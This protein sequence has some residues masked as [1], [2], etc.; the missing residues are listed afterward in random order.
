MEDAGL[1]TAPPYAAPSQAWYTVGVLT[2]AWLFAYLDRQI[3]I[4]LIESLRSSIALS[5][6]QISLVQGF[7]FSLFFVLAGIPIGRLTDRVSRKALLVVGM[8]FWSLMTIA[9]GFAHSFPELFLARLGVGV[10]EACL[11]PAS[12]SIVSDYFSPD[13]RG[14][15]MGIMIAGSPAGSAFSIL[16]GGVILQYFGSALVPVPVLGLAAPWQLTFFCVGFPGLFVVLLLFF[17]V[18]EP[19]RHERD[20][21]SGIHFYP[22]LVQ[23]RKGFGLIYLAYTMN[24]IMG[25]GVSIWTPVVLMRVHHFPPAK[26]GLLIGLVLL[27]AAPVSSACAGWLGDRLTRVSLLDG[28][29]R[30]MV[31]L[32]PVQFL[33]AFLLLVP[34]SPYLT[35]IAFAGVTFF[36][37]MIGASSYPAIH[38][39]TP[40]EMRG[41]AIAVYLLCANLVGLGLTPTI[42][43]L[44]TDRVFADPMK[45]PLSIVCVV[46]PA[47]VLGLLVTMLLLPVYR[48]LRQRQ[49]DVVARSAGRG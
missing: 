28:R 43:A 31:L 3:I 13:R 26:V 15:A 30:M 40:N 48:G 12:F 5:D 4:I 21:Q 36:G 27:V 33:L 41:Q 46:T 44:M 2:F 20:P 38:D 6:T 19:V 9:C 23:Y 39:I 32:F 8:L 17:T 25:Y 11:A 10:G 37:Q 49:L 1:Q 14:R 34:D 35:V 42:I 24:F 45:V 29:V 22:F 18:K 47:M 7:A 16:L